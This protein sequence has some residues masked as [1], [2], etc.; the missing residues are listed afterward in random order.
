MNQFNEEIRPA[1]ELQDEVDSSLGTL[2][3]DQPDEVEAQ[4]DLHQSESTYENTSHGGLPLLPPKN[5]PPPGRLPQRGDVAPPPTLPPRQVR[6]G[7]P[8]YT[9]SQPQGAAAAAHGSGFGFPAG[10][11]QGDPDDEDGVSVST[12]SGMQPDDF[13]FT[14]VSTTHPAPVMRFPEVDAPPPA[15]KL[16]LPPPPTLSANGGIKSIYLEIKY[17]DDNQAPR[18]LYL[19][20]CSSRAVKSALIDGVAYACR[21]SGQCH[22]MP[23]SPIFFVSGCILGIRLSVSGGSP[24]K[25]RVLANHPL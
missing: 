15:D 6:F 9:P 16:P 11:G 23:P 1:D 5:H 3:S 8:L 12:T 21:Q 22:T 7:A 18:H 25:W 20:K 4:V 17:V 10:A 19:P 2:D 13:D 14:V 24:V